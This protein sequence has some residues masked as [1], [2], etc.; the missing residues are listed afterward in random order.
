VVAAALGQVELSPFLVKAGSALI[1]GGN[2]VVAASLASRSA[3]AIA[4]AVSSGGGGGGG[5]PAP[6]S[7]RAPD[8]PETRQSQGQQVAS[9]NGVGPGPRPPLIRAGEPFGP[10]DD[11]FLLQ[12][13]FREILGDVMHDLREQ[14]FQ[15]RVVSGFRTREQ[16]AEKVRLGY[17]RTM[18]S[19]HRLGLGADII[20][21]RRGY[22]PGGETDPIFEALRQS[23]EE[24]G[25]G[26][27]GN[28]F[29]GFDDPSHVQPLFFWRY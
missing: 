27:G 28:L 14:G 23:A 10:G 17:S 5:G 3:F 19:P 29:R 6:G 13:W 18:N 16:Q 24:H 2:T 21:R 20:D 8:A 26:W 12:P 22:P 9:A 25:L 15:P 7:G 1:W 11:V 4:G